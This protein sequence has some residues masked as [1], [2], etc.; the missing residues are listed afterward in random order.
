MPT[1]PSTNA[2]ATQRNAAQ[3]LVATLAAH[4]VDRVFCVPGESFLAV[5]DSLYE[6]P[7][8]DCVACRHEGGAGMMALAD[9]KLT[10]RPGVVLV[11]RGPGATNVSIA[12]HVAEQ[13]AVPLV[14]FVGQVERKDI[15][16]G[17]FQEVDYKKSLGG[18]CKGVW[19]VADGSQLAAVCAKAFSRAQRG[20]PGPV[21]ISLPE[22]MQFDAAEGPSPPLPAARRRA[23]PADA[24]ARTLALLEEAERPLMILGGAFPAGQN[25]NNSRL[26]V[27]VA[28]A[29]AVPV[30]AGWKNQHRFP[31]AHPH[32][33]GHLGYNIPAVHL[34]LLS[35]ADLLIAVGTR[36]GDVT[37]QGYRF[38]AAPPSDNGAQQRLVHVYP[39]AEALSRVYRPQ[40]AVQSDCGRFLEALLKRAPGRAPSPGRAAARHN[41]IARLHGY[42]AGQAH[43]NGEE[44]ADG[45]VFGALTSALN[46][47]LPEDAIIVQ[48]GGNH[49]SW[50]HR[51]YS[52]RGGETLLA[53][54]AGAMGFGVPGAV[55]ASLRHPG[56]RVVCI[57]GDGGL[58]MTGNELATA[59]QH[60]ATPLIIVSNNHSYGTIRQHQEKHYPGRVKA[61]GL[62]N[63]DLL[64][65]GEAF[66]VPSF[67]IER[68]QQ[69]EAV[70][71]E[72]LAVKGPAFVEVK[73]SLRHISA[74]ATLPD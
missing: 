46:G 35:P 43:W 69:V 27:R 55:A 39:A 29:L 49:S 72:A 12:I 66:G 62:N 20:V 1:L 32:Y 11:S 17:A 45:V 18:M 15:G 65:W 71:K 16:R 42:A 58:L 4:G 26:A 50:V 61:T 59:V 8:I 19:E 44:A 40:L 64:R 73:T 57:L 38:P 24:I 47:L 67:R 22:D 5:L 63:P 13:D 48:D 31:N 10:G 52:F 68:Q 51:Y 74:F 37:S 3:A 14:V 7:A 28:E 36:L 41:W 30:A 6:T 60:G 25:E 54:S 34:E 23:P 33:A 56:R 2:A 21:L 9:A 53:A 70:L